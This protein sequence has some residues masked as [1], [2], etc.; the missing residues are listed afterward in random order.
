MPELIVGSA[1]VAVGKDVVGFGGLLELFIGLGVI[2]IPVRVV[3]HGN[4]AVGL[5][6][7]LFVCAFADAEHF[8]VV[9]FCHNPFRMKAKL[10]K[11]QRGR[12]RPALSG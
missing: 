8:V 7:F 2:R 10:R 11:Q 5:L 12:M 6:D 1:L 3:L 9:A 4:P